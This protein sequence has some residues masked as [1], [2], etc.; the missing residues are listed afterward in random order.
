MLIVDGYQGKFRLEN[1]ADLERRLDQ[2]SE[3]SGYLLLEQVDGDQVSLFLLDRVPLPNTYDEHYLTI[4]QK[5]YDVMEA[6][7]LA[8]F[9]FN[10]SNEPT[11]I[12]VDI[13]PDPLDEYLL[14]TAA[15]AGLD[16]DS[17]LQLIIQHSGSDH[18]KSE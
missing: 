6:R 4:A 2:F 14:I 15:S 3:G 8:R 12:G 7:G 18:T 1:N 10:Q 9:D 13:A 17:I 11:L 16:Q 5:A